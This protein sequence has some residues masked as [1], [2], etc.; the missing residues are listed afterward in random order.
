MVILSN[1]S[2]L[3]SEFLCMCV[4]PSDISGMLT[5]I[6]RHEQAL[7][8]FNILYESAPIRGN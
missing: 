1:S 5:Y 7:L 3:T 2:K 8:H 6:E 4:A